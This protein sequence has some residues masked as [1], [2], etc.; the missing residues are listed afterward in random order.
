[1]T[2]SMLAHWL[3]L[4]LARG[5]GAATQRNLLAAFGLP[6]AIFAASRAALA[7]VVG[8]RMAQA[9]LAEPDTAQIERTLAWANEPDNHL[10]TLADAEYPPALL[11]SADPPVLLYVKG[12]VQALHAANP[13]A[14]VGARTA[15]PQGLSN[16]RAFAQQLAEDGWM[17][18]SG[19]AQGI[20]AAAHEGA[21]AA[22]RGRT[23]AFVGTGLDRVYPAAHRDLAHRIA[24]RGALVSE[25]AL[26]TPPRP[27][28]FPRRNRLIAGLAR[29]VLVVEASLQSGSLITARLALESGREVFAIPGSIHSPQARGCHRLIREGARL[30]ETM[31][32]I[33]EELPPRE[34]AAPPPEV[35]ASAPPATNAARRK[36]APQHHDAPPA[37]APQNAAAATDA[38][39][40]VLAAMGFDPVDFDAVAERCDLTAAD[41]QVILLQ[42]EMAGKVG[43]MAGGLLQRLA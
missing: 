26:G 10:L 4:V 6:E 1:M 24:A 41:L 9:V 29:G 27:G 34:H 18:V 3:R 28:H 30:V 14:I 36:K 38:E 21:L 22:A 43:R 2:Q 11:E 7:A 16:A 42:L 23:V 5:V 12:D 40:Q 15:T 32:D 20:D 35:A 33:L 31:A 39:A 19:L 17:V 37:S 8:T 13:L 25:F